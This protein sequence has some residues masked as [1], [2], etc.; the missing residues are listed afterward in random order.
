MKYLL[1]FLATI[2][3]VVV[4]FILVLRGFSSGPK[5]EP[6]KL[7]DYAKTTI[8]VQYNLDGEIN[9]DQLHRGYRIVIDRSETRIEIYQGYQNNVIKR[10]VYPNNDNSY[11]NFLRALDLAKFTRGNTDSKAG[12]ERGVCAIGNRYVYQVEGGEKANQRFWSTSCGGGTFGG[13]P[14]QVRQLFQQQIP[15]FSKLTSGIVF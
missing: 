4:V 3:L 7:A 6:I 5:K 15:D 13:N 1:G 9:A 10:Q 12:D 14:T 2:A 8:S 11:I